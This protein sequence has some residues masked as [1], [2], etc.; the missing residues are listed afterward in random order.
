MRDFK[1]EI[2]KEREKRRNKSTAATQDIYQV[3]GLPKILEAY[4]HKPEAFGLH[5]HNSQL[6]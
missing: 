6:N 2:D 4:I 3:S 5:Q 1:K